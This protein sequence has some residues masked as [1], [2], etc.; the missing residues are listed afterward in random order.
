MSYLRGRVASLWPAVDLG[1]AL[2]QHGVLLLE[3]KPAILLN[4]LVCHHLAQLGAVVGRVRVAIGREDLAH[5]QH[6]RAAADG[7]RH[8]TDRPAAP[9]SSHRDQ[10]HFDVQLQRKEDL[11]VRIGGFLSSCGLQQSTLPESSGDMAGMSCGHSAVKDASHGKRPRALAACAQTARLS[12]LWAS[13]REGERKE[14]TSL[15]DKRTIDERHAS[16]NVAHVGRRDARAGLPRSV[17]LAWN[18]RPPDDAVRVVALGLA[19]G[20]AVVGPVGVIGGVQT[21]LLLEGLGLG[22]QLVEDQALRPR[23]ASAWGQARC[24]GGGRRRFNAGSGQIL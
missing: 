12:R 17:R 7:V 19:G 13:S 8:H 6:M 5:D 23:A 4:H 21:H 9:C 15:A 2:L 24:G 1:G 10:T 20:G 16:T 18:Q 3:A 11:A 14:T 22:T